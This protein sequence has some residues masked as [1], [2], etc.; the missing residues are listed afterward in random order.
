MPPPSAWASVRTPC[1]AASRQRGGRLSAT[2]QDDERDQPWQR[3]ESARAL[4]LGRAH[5]PDGPS[6]QARRLQRGSQ[7]LVHEG[8]HGGECRSAR[9]QH[10]RVEALQQLAGDVERDVWPRLEVCSDSPD[11]DS[12]LAHAQAVRERPGSSLA[13]ERLDLGHRLQP[14]SELLDAP[15]VEPQS[16]ERACVEP[17]GRRLDVNGVCLEQESLLRPHERGRSAQGP[18]HGVVA[19]RRGRPVGLGRLALDRLSQVHSSAL[20]VPVVSYPRTPDGG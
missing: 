11:R 20:T 3:D 12:A 18:G 15:V 6:R 19:Q 17:A 1:S 9:P 7:D 5:E 10:R 14:A 8:G 13:L 16:V 2:A 4:A